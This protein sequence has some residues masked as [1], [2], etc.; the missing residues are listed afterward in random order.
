MFKFNI[1]TKGK[2]NMHVPLLCAINSMNIKQVL[3][4]FSLQNSKEI[5]ARIY[6]YKIYLYCRFNLQIC[7][8]FHFRQNSPAIGAPLDKNNELICISQPIA[9]ETFCG[10]T[11]VIRRP[12]SVVI[13]TPSQHP[14][15]TIK[16]IMWTYDVA[17]VTTTATLMSL[18]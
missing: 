9:T 15:I 11:H 17:I 1:Q 12:L 6:D 18:H 16:T 3:K 13:N 8:A 14:Y 5:T 4:H 2:K 7:C 10:L